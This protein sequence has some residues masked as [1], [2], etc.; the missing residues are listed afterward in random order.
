MV[1]D[2]ENLRRAVFSKEIANR[3]GPVKRGAPRTTIP[4][5]LALADPDIHNSL[6]YSKD[7][8]PLLDGWL[9]VVYHKYK[10]ETKPFR[11]QG[12]VQ[13]KDG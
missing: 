7:S 2:D 3:V 1:P 11:P 4:D 6:Y 5:L 10:Y 13:R 12:E 8:F 9:L